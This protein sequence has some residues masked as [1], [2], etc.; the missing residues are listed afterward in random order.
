MPTKP[1]TTTPEDESSPVPTI[2]ENV[3]DDIPD[4]ALPLSVQEAIV[5][6]ALP[7]PSVDTFSA[8]EALFL[9]FAQSVQRKLHELLIMDHKCLERSYGDT[10]NL[11]KEWLQ[12][13]VLTQQRADLDQAVFEALAQRSASPP[14]AVT[15]QA[16]SP[17]GYVVQFRVEQ[18][19]AEQLIDEVER[20]TG[21][22]AA[23]H[24]TAMPS[25]VAF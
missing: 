14:Y 8:H 10:F 15:V 25:A 2:T 22:L 13:T 5:S 1:R 6:P 11:V 18:P 24:Y 23:Q 17:A 4:P 16:L 12:S 20:L 9:G 19:T 3:L 21:W 7:M